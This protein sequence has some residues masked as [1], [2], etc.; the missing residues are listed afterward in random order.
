MTLSRK[1]GTTR[2]EAL[3]KRQARSEFSGLAS[4]E[5]RKLTKNSTEPFAKDNDQQAKRGKSEAEEQERGERF[6]SKLTAPLPSQ[7]Q[8]VS[9]GQK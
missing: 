1:E 9:K 2:C 7:T 6:V 4:I 5:P 3:S 8:G